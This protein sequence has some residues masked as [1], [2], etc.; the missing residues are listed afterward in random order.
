MDRP[1]GGLN[2]L[3]VGDFWQLD[4][5]DGGFLADIPTQYLQRARRY[6]P[7]PTISH[8]QSLFWGGPLTGI[9][10][11]TE[12]HECERTQDQWLQEVQ[13]EFRKGAVS[14]DTYNFLHGRPTRV[15]GSWLNGDVCCGNDK[16]R[17]L[18]GLSSGVPRD[19]LL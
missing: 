3:C 4:P 9:Q 7:A 13:E 2:V 6:Q 1:F 17:A 8:G 15:P 12:L 16:C 19:N 14:L 5:P 18:A 10:G 11:V